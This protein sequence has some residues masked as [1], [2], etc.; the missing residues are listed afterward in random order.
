MKKSYVVIVILMINVFSAFA[1]KTKIVLHSFSSQPERLTLSNPWASTHAT[2]LSMQL[3]PMQKVDC[4][5]DI[6]MMRYYTLIYGKRQYAFFIEPGKDL[7]LEVYPAG[8]LLVKGAYSD[9]NNFLIGIQSEDSVSRQEGKRILY[10]AIEL[11]G[12]RFDIYTT[13]YR[14]HLNQ[15]KNRKF[16]GVEE[17]LAIGCIQGIYLKNIY[18]L[19]LD[20]KVFGKTFKVHVAENYAWPL[21]KLKIVPELVYYPE[22]GDFLREWMYTKMAAGKVRLKNP[23]LWISEWAE[24][25]DN[26]FLRDCF[27]DYLTGKEMLMGYFDRWTKERFEAAKRLVKDVEIAKRLDGRIAGIPDAVALPDVSD[28][29]FENVSG[30]RISLETFKGKYVLIDIWGLACSPCIG[31]MP[32]FH[33]LSDKFKNEKIEFVSIAVERDRGNWK[34]FLNQKHLTGNQFIMTDLN[35]NP[36]WEKIGLSGIPRFVLVGPDSKVLVKHCYRPS[37]L[38][39]EAQLK[40]LLQ[41]K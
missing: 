21:V 1:E 41:E 15:L 3:K 7:E 37:N 31:E 16:S 34:N 25:F 2:L 38:V 23:Q 27:I 26:S 6:S 5:I 8:K 14:N 40:Y 33:A 9:L 22:W 13:L 30:E 11:N 36:I 12:D 28:C 35:K 19:L 20:S 4:E 17:K 24:C 10:E 32:Y 29:T 39:L 18:K